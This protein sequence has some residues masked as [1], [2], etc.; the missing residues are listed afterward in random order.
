[1]LKYKTLHVVLMYYQKDL[2]LYHATNKNFKKLFKQDS[3]PVGCPPPACQPY[4]FWWPRL[5][6]SGRK[7]GM[8]SCEQ[9]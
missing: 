4:V 6:V 1:M 7:G 2:C 9:F 5:D 8:A 3:I